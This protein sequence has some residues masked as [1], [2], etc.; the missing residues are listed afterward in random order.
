MAEFPEAHRFT[1]DLPARAGKR[2]ARQHAW[3]C[4]SDVCASVGRALAPIA[5]ASD[6]IELFAIEVRELNPPPGE[7]PILW[8][9]LTTHTVEKEGL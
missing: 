2:S 6:E 5:N 1:L 7:K 4:A 3:R 8:R 9:L